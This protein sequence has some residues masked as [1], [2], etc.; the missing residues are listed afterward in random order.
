[1]LETW[2]SLG[3]SG[4]CEAQ[5]CR[6]RSHGMVL[7]RRHR[8]TAGSPVSRRAAHAAAFGVDRHR[9][10]PVFYH[11]PRDPAD[12]E[13]LAHHSPSWH[14][15]ERGA[16]PL[17]SAVTC[18]RFGSTSTSPDQDVEQSGEC[19]V[20]P[21]LPSRSSQKRRGLLLLRR[22]RN[23]DRSS[24]GGDL[25]RLLAQP[26]IREA[27]PASPPSCSMSCNCTR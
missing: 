4:P 26:V 1:M 25:K 24:A 2:P 15:L 17:W 14:R 27:S 18:H 22:E 8:G 13:A 21:T 3:P 6:H 9:A 19:E 16:V 11:R 12:V 20:E 23:V 7:P 10:N 5:P